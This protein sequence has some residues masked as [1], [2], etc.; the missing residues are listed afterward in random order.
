MN[1]RSPCTVSPGKCAILAISTVLSTP[2][3][4]AQGV[5]NTSDRRH[6]HKDPEPIWS[7]T[8]PYETSD[9]I[10][11]LSTVIDHMRI[12]EDAKT[13]TIE[14]DTAAIDAIRALGFNVEIDS[15]A[16]Q[17]IQEFR[18][19]RRDFLNRQK[20]GAHRP[21]AIQGSPQSKPGDPL[22]AGNAACYRTV[23]KTNLDIDAL[24]KQYPH[25]IQVVPIGQ[26][27]V[28]KQALSFRNLL[29]KYLPASVL[30]LID[31]DLLP[32]SSANAIR[33]VVIGNKAVIKDRKVPAWSPLRPSMHAST[34]PRKISALHRMA[35]HE[36]RHGCDRHLASQQQRVPLHLA[37]QPDGRKLA[38]QAVGSWRKNANLKDAF[39]KDQPLKSGVDLNRN[40]PFGWNS[41]KG[42]GSSGSSVQKPTEEKLLRQSRKP[43]PSSSTSQVRARRAATSLAECF[44]IGAQRQSA[45]SELVHRTTTKACTSTFTASANLFLWPWGIRRASIGGTSQTANDD[46]MAAFGQR[47][48]WYNKYRATQMINYN[49]DGV[50]TDTFY[51]ELG[52][53]SFTIELGKVLLRTVQGIREG[54]LPE[55]RVPAIRRSNAESALSVAAG[56][57]CG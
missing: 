47:M 29:I 45:I 7:V 56:A 48:A 5:A 51:G 53:P 34:R 36:L 41:T 1:Q 31:F 37:C 16:S 57:R 25:L 13:V 55:H 9:D 12:D 50:T 38:E 24:A 43:R 15:Q 42:A 23:E 11:R 40:F 4:N 30:A 32:D 19:H 3:S 52:A 27:W 17:V 18:G 26:T 54:N 28:Q 21:N 46:G 33:V 49:V 8:V 39:C 22:F 6:R 35:G 14:V 10:Q 44:R 2:Y 20:S